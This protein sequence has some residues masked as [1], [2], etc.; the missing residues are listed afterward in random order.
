MLL[1]VPLESKHLFTPKVNFGKLKTSVK[2]VQE[3]MMLNAV[4]VVLRPPTCAS[5]WL[6]SDWISDIYGENHVY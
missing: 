4:S 6:C 3:S 5:F 1:R 2:A